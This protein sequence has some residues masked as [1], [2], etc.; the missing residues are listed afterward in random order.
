MVMQ[1]A[2]SA[3]ASRV[4]HPVLGFL[5]LTAA[6]LGVAGAGLNF[7]VYNTGLPVLSGVPPI[8]PAF[9]G[10]Y[11]II[12]GF[13]AVLGYGALFAVKYISV[14]RDRAAPSATGPQ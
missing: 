3:F 8:I 10:V 11:A 14:L 12:T 13:L 7:V 2:T 5:L 4:D 6:L 9:L 1:Y